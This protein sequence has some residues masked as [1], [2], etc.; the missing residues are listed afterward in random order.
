MEDARMSVVWKRLTLTVM[1]VV[2]VL[3]F[4]SQAQVL[5]YP[6]TGAS[7]SKMLHEMAPP[8]PTTRRNR[9]AFLG[10]IPVAVTQTRDGAL[11]TSALPYP[12]LLAAGLNFEGLGAGFPNY[13][14]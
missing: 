11:Q 3:S 1:L 8:A 12:T 10:R 13:S 2:V 6:A 5:V 4:D 9:E 7:W 14:V